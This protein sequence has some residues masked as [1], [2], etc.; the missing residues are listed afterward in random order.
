MPTA[1]GHTGRVRDCPAGWEPCSPLGRDLRKG[2]QP[3]TR[4]EGPWWSSAQI[5]FKVGL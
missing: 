1:K 3:Y 2:P 4:N 5:W